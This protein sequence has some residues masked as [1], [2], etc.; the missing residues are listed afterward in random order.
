MAICVQE[1]FK[2][3]PDAI[4]EVRE[5]AD[6]C[7]YYAQQARAEAAADR[8]ARADRRAQHAAYRG[9]RRVGDDR[10]V[11][12]P[13]GDLPR[14][15]AWRRWSR[16]T[17]SSPSPRRRRRGSPRA[18]CELAH[19]AGVPEDA[20]VLRARRAGGRRGADR[21]RADPG[22][23]FTGSTATAKKIARAL[24]DDETRP[25]VPLIAETGGINAMIVDSTALP[26][27][28]VA[29][30]IDLGVPIGGA[31]LLGAA[32]A[33][34]AGGYRRRRDRDAV[35]RDGDAGDRRSGRSARPMSGR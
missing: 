15:D 32:A 30:V 14:A 12:L 26:E 17:P 8:T 21:G 22:V 19:E 9:P 31:A 29:D 25:I 3:I 28:V 16:A 11:E 27:Q 33:A 20:L 35:G 1:A 10:A 13:A 5:A 2:T 4:G 24:L 34:G 18:R 7:R 6:F 23:A